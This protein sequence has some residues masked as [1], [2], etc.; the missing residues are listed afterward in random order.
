[1]SA[2]G[3][4]IAAV[5]AAVGGMAAAAGA[6]LMLAGES[7]EP[8]SGVADGGEGS[9]SVAAGRRAP[10]LSGTDPITGETISLTEFRGKAVVINIWAS[11]CTACTAEADDLRRFARSHP[12]IVVL[13]IDFQDTV[14]AAK[15]FYSDSGWK[16]PS[17]SDPSGALAAGLGLESLP[18][19]ICLNREHREAARIVAAT[20]LAGF[21]QCLAAAKAAV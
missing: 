3:L 7:G 10:E 21:E 4:K 14:S 20:N 17:I 6:G 2:R 9:P 18:S 5:V 15:D 19:T 16:H 8:A 12:E 11:W 13:G 1:M